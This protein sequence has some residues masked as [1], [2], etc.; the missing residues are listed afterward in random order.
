MI[1][2]R[3]PIAP[4]H[5]VF[6]PYEEL[7]CPVC[8]RN[9]RTDKASSVVRRETG[10]VIAVG[11]GGIFAFHTALSRAL[12]PPEQPRTQPWPE[13]LRQ[14]GLAWAGLAVVYIVFLIV[15]AEGLVD[16]SST[17][18]TRVAVIAVGWFGIIGPAWSSWRLYLAKQKEIRDLPLWSQAR[19]RWWRLYYCSRDDVVFVADEDRA[20]SPDQV[21]DLLYRR[22]GPSLVR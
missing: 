6:S 11:S 2:E 16:P 22:E 7:A 12:A 18:V 19:E 20:E 5:E 3:E 15:T 9:D 1:A 14:I 8:R 21:L 10:Q 17:L 13:R 4:I